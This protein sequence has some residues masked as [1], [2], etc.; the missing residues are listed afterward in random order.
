MKALVVVCLA[1][2]GIAFV[3]VALPA[4]VLVPIAAGLQRWLASFQRRLNQTFGGAK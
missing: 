1:L 2:E 4:L 3:A